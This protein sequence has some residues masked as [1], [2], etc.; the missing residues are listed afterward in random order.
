MIKKAKYFFNII[1]FF[2]SLCLLFSLASATFF[3]QTKHYLSPVFFYIFSKIGIEEKMIKSFVNRKELKVKKMI[4]EDCHVDLENDSEEKIALSL[5]DF[6]FRTTVRGHTPTNLK[7]ASQRYLFAHYTPPLQQLCSGYVTEFRYLLNHAGLQSRE[8]GLASPSAFNKN[9]GDTH[10]I[11]EAFIN[12]KW[13]LL[14][15]TFNCYWNCSDGRRMLSLQE[16]HS[17]IKSGNTLIAQEGIT[18]IRDYSLKEYYMDFKNLIYA[19]RA[20]GPDGT[21]GDWMLFK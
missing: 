8:Y 6:V 1:T 21:F 20:E 4:E 19:Y 16:L 13:V 14:D 17:C 10:A 9:S 7:E 2:F 15:P 12:K 3:S 18:K 11:L 5:M